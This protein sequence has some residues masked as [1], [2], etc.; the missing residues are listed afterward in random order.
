MTNT[1]RNNFQSLTSSVNP[2]RNGFRKKF[3]TEVSAD[4]DEPDT[5]V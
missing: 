2:S 3:A 1:Y 5:V 4:L